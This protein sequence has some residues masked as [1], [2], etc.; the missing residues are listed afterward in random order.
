MKNI[1]ENDVID[2]LPI[3]RAIEVVERAFIDY[4]IGLI[5]I[6]HRGT[7]EVNSE[8]NACLFLPAVHKEKKY[9][10]LNTQPVFRAARKSGCQPY[11]V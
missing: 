4:A 6:G 8:G 9:S 1:S 11:K 7:L 5:T 10:A 2:L 3:V